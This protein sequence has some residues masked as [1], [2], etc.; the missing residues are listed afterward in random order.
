M[1]LFTLFIIRMITFNNCL[2]LF[3]YRFI[4]IMIKHRYGNVLH[5]WLLKTDSSLNSR[6]R[7]RHL[8][9]QK[10]NITHGCINMPRTTHCLY[11]HPRNYRNRESPQ[12]LG[13]KNIDF[14]SMCT[15][16]ELVC[17]HIKLFSR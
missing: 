17:R 5:Y 7:R 3:I 1:Y 14:L 2:N 4:G 13:V 12:K 15:I 10:T 8:L 11:S 9:L 6:N 16:Q